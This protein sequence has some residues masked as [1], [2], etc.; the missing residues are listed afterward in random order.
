MQNSQISFTS[1]INFTTYPS[2]YRGANRISGALSVHHPWTANEIIRASE[3][4]TKDVRTC[5]A[6]GIITKGDNTPLEV[7]MFHMSPVDEWPKN[8]DFGLFEKVISRK[9]R[10]SEPIQAF[11]LGSKKQRESE[12]VSSLEMFNKIENFIQKLGIPYS[13]FKGLPLNGNWADIAYD[14]KKDQWLVH[15]SQLK[16]NPSAYFDEI[17]LC[18]K[19]ELVLDLSA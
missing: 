3:A 16:R 14:G 2:W 6:G 4:Y 11:L 18:S 9:L 15:C 10:T 8:K 1:R 17:Q 5:T 7:V 19:D 12:F 13:K